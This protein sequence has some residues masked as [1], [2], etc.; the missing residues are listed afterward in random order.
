MNYYSEQDIREL[1]SEIEADY[2]FAHSTP[3]NVRL[4]RDCEYF[5]DHPTIA[6]M[7]YCAFH[8]DFDTIDEV[9]N[10]WLCDENDFCNGEWVDQCLV[11]A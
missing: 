5:N 1:V 7:A 10:W 11:L 9:P 8:T 4:C 6:G 3:I 2:L